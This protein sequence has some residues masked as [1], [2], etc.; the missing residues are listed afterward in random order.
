MLECFVNGMAGL[1][2]H[3]ADSA[4][5]K[6]LLHPIFLFFSPVKCR[7]IGTL[8]GVGLGQSSIVGQLTA[9]SVVPFCN[10]SVMIP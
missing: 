7:C 3:K 2:T 5:P 8:V 1:C 6:P 10:D 4:E 9:S